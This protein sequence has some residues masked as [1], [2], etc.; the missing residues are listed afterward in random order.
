MAE[1][2]LIT[3]A[4]VSAGMIAG[5]LLS[6]I[7]K[8][9]YCGNNNGNTAYRGMGIPFAG[10]EEVVEPPVHHPHPG[11]GRKTFEPHRFH[12]KKHGEE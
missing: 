10:A 3:G 8:G 6:P 1:K 12:G 11:C 5:F 7:K 2:I 9:I 4:M